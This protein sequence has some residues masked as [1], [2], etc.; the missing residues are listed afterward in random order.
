MSKKPDGLND[1][2][3]DLVGEA[4]KLDDGTCAVI[5]GLAKYA[6]EFDLTISPSEFLEM[7]MNS[8]LKDRPTF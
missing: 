1:V 2:L 8:L 5:T 3:C 4:M 7:T 6:Q